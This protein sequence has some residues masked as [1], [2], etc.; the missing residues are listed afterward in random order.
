[1]KLLRLAAL[2]ATLAGLVAAPA[3]ADTIKVG[4]IGPLSGPFGIFG[5]NFKA[6]IDAYQAKAGKTVKGHTVEFVYRDLEAIDPAKAKALAQELIVKERVQYLAGAYFTPDA[7]AIATVIDQ[8]KTPFVVMNAATSSITQKSPLVSRSS[9]TMW[10]ITVP[11]AKAAIEEGAKRMVVAVSDYGPGLDAEAAF[12][13]T[14]EAEGGTVTD[15]IRMPVRTTDFGPIMQRVK[16]TKADAVF[17]FLPS[18]PPTLAFV[19]A[20]IDNGLKAAGI[21]LITTGDLTMEPDLPAL[22]EAGLGIISTYGYATSHDSPE[23]KAFLAD[24][25]KVGL[26][27]KE[28]VMTA[29]AAYDGARL[30]YR[31]IEATDGKQ[32]PAKAM[33]AIKGYAWE[34]PRGPV[35]IDPKTRHIRQNIYKRVVEKRDGAY[36]NREIKAYPDQPDFGLMQ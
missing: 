5:K 17:A 9:F 30:L 36:I 8:G 7:L 10:Q 35:S 12:R 2:A 26:P 6:G 1:M 4:V 18:G 19:K 16:D 34:S 24:L 3:V 27:E 29:V 31:M 22:G 23:N 13:K 14:F 20:F 25:A 15:S 32:D 21:K 11:A 33:D 28:V